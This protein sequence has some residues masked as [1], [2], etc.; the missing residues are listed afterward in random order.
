MPDTTPGTGESMVNRD[1]VIIFIRIWEGC[2][3]VGT[4]IGKMRIN[5]IRNGEK[6]SK[7]K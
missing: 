6:S 4:D 1:M 3:S 7:E 5:I 2:E